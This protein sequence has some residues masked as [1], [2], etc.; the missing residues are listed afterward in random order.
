MLLLCLEGTDFVWLD[1]DPEEDG[2]YQ[3]EEGSGEE[4]S[5]DEGAGT[6]HYAAVGY[7]LFV[8]AC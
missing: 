5:E 1:F 7:V 8:F 3:S 6:E 4:S 2:K